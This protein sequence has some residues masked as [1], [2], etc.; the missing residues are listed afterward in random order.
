M[1]VP[2]IGSKA[3]KIQVVARNPEEAWSRDILGTRSTPLHLFLAWATKSRVIAV[4]ARDRLY[5]RRN[6]NL[7]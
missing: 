4:I 3:I 2:P 6:R 7:R 5:R 1:I